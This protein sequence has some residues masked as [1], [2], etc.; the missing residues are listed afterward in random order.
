MVTESKNENEKVIKQL[1]LGVLLISE[2]RKDEDKIVI[3][4]NRLLEQVFG[5]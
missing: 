3:A 2:G 1:S 4:F 5:G